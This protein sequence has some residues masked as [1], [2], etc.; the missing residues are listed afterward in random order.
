[1]KAVTNKIIKTKYS[2]VMALTHRVGKFVI[3]L[4]SVWTCQVSGRAIRGCIHIFPYQ[5]ACLVAWQ[6]IN[7]RFTQ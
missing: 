4:V 5:L 1:M 6:S 2:M 7:K 3:A